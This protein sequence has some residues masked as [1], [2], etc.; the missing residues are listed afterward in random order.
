MKHPGGMSVFCR[1]D[2]RVVVVWMSVFLSCGCPCHYRVDVRD[3]V[4]WMSVLLSR[5]YPCYY[6][7]DFRV[8][9]T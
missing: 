6:R 5:G 1:V 4:A 3:V 7:V 2:V 9:V 8:A